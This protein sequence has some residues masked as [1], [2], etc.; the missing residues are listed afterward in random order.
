MTILED[1]LQQ[2]SED[3]L[4]KP[5]GPAIP[6]AVD[7][8]MAVDEGNITLL[9]RTKAYAVGQCSECG[10]VICCNL[11]E[12]FEGDLAILQASHKNSTTD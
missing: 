6:S 7:Q 5:V 4:Q 3:G 11:F 10:A 12:R 2:V 9:R 8:F 1:Y